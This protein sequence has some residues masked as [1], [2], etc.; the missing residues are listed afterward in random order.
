[1]GNLRSAVPILVSLA[2]WTAAPF[3]PRNSY[4]QSQT[5]REKRV[6]RGNTA[7]LEKQ[8][9]VALLVGIGDY[10][11][12]LTGL[13]QLKYPVADMMA[14]AN[15]LK[16]QGYSPHLLQDGKASAPRIRQYLKD[17][18]D[19]VEPGA[20]TFV[21]YFSGHGYR[22]G[23]ENYLATSD[24]TSFDDLA[25]QGLSVSEVQRLLADSGARQRI[26]FIDACRNDPAKSASKAR[27]FE[28]F[29]TAE[30]L[31]VL[32]S[33]APGKLSYEDDDL[34][35][36]VFSY[37]LAKGL[38]GAAAGPDGI[39]SFDDLKTWM[40]AQM[41]DY[42]AKHSRVQVPYQLGES[43]GD[44]LLG[45]KLDADVTA[46]VE[47][48]PT[49]V[50]P[51]NPTPDDPPARVAR[52]SVA[53][54]SVSLRP[55]GL[56]EW[57]PAEVNRPIVTGDRLWLDAMSHA[58]LEFG[59]GALRLAE[60]T[61]F[62]LVNLNDRV[63]Q[64]GITQGTLSVKL[65]KLDAGATIEVDTPNS[66]V[67]LLASGEYRFNV[68]DDGRRTVVNVDS[69]SAHGI[70]GSR[71]FQ[72]QTAQAM[73]I[74]GSGSAI[75]T[76]A[77][78]ATARTPDPYFDAKD[79]RIEK[80]TVDSYVPSGTVGAE[81]LDNNGT[82][83]PL[84]GYGM[85]WMPSGMPS[86]WEPYRNGHWAWVDPWGWTWIDDAPWGFA[87]FH[88]GRWILAGRAWVWLP[89]GAGGSAVYAPA[90]VGWTD[91]VGGGDNVGW[92][93]LGPGEPYVPAYRFSLAYWHRVNMSSVNLGVV[94]W[95]TVDVT[96][97]PYRNRMYITAMSRDSFV[98]ATRVSARTAIGFSAGEIM[99]AHVGNVSGLAPQRT[100]LLAPR[101]AHEP[102]ARPPESAASREVAHRMVAPPP[103]ASFAQEQQQLKRMQG[104]PMAAS[105]L[106]AFAP[107]SSP[108]AN[109]W[110]QFG[111]PPL[112]MQPDPPKQL[113]ND[114]GRPGYNQQRPPVPPRPAPPQPRYFPPQPNPKRLKQPVPGAPKP[115]GPNL[116]RQKVNPYP[117][118]SPGAGGKNPP[119]N[120]S[121][122]QAKPAGK[123]PAP[124]KGAAPAPRSAP[125]PRAAPA[126]APARG[127]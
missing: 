79:R 126:P 125:A 118:G 77:S 108:A 9:N 66:A 95:N 86:G 53:D 63:T 22:V 42:G 50:S 81:D 16:L 13:S 62:A 37:Y 38:R 84:R 97:V 90:L 1:M 36:G 48:P 93:P 101:R 103:P 32:Y 92:F 5:V 110:G 106:R 28:Q 120:G 121:Q 61:S 75:T 25:Q 24:V 113:T 4:A 116:P 119:A 19:T 60:K 26:V 114:P 6:S 109:P 52:L 35:H 59:N 29:A 43:S 27:P 57:T 33:T 73:T 111:R 78:A 56:E 122:G 2:V 40:N 64:V 45:K 70:A 3:T 34:G 115:A 123:T 85:A 39:V 46:A 80:S 68:S 76:V 88:Y 8:T 67:S 104:R 107:V 102:V 12:S 23:G 30:G 65:R 74:S 112:P 94:K 15:A 83:S 14:V 100:S 89:G 124:A 31:R 20:G 99:R 49:P 47:A 96:R 69:G 44:F 54:G 7:V 98:N 127:K 17:L 11:T 72:I 82:W 58:E 51:V 10:D 21:F 91:G 71:T 105:E 18:K 55:A 117:G 87:P 41:M